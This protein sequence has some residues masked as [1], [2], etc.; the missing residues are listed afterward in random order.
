MQEWQVRHQLGEGTATWGALWVSSG[1]GAR[2]APRAEGSPGDLT[3]T[4][5]EDRS[6]YGDWAATAFLLLLPSRLR[7]L[8]AARQG[9]VGSLFP[10]RACKPFLKR[11]HVSEPGFFQKV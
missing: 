3:V 11:G 8:P 7:P 1:P 4:Q 5:Q 9:P 2:G 6:G 10:I